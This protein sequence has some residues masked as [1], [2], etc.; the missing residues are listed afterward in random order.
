MPFTNGYDLTTEISLI[1]NT[2]P[3]F[4]YVSARAYY[5]GKYI[6]YKKLLE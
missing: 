6:D 5:D 1:A 4:S 3:D 2:H